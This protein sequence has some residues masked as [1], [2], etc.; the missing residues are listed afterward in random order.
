MYY[1]L[2]QHKLLTDC[3]KVYRQFD[4]IQLGYCIS[5]NCVPKCIHIAYC[6]AASV[7]VLAYV[8]V[9]W[10]CVLRSGVPLRESM[11]KISVS[12]SVSLPIYAITASL[13]VC[14]CVGDVSSDQR[15]LC[16]GGPY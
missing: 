11:Y 3:S 2:V 5:L 7:V 1:I 9:C 8:C 16:R 6:L 4:G 10:G 15:C 14:A 13:S 12:L